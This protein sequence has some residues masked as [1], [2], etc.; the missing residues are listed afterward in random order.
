M[1]MNPTSIMSELRMKSDKELQD[2]AAMHKNDPFIFPL[3]FQESQTRQRMRTAEQAKAA[4]QNQPKVVDQDLAQMS[5]MPVMSGYGIPVT[6]GDGSPVMSGMPEDSGIAQLSAKNL[7]GMAGGGIVAFEE[8]GEVPRFQNTG[9][10]QLP[11][12]V[13]GPKGTVYVRQPNHTDEYWAN[14]LEK[15]APD[16]L[17]S[18]ATG[19]V[20]QALPGGLGIYSQG[21]FGPQAGDAALQKRI[22]DIEANP[23]MQRADKDMLIAKARQ[24]FGLPKVTTIPPTTPVQFGDKPATTTPTTT[25]GTSPLINKEQSVVDKA[26][27]RKRL[28]DEA[29]AQGRKLPPEPGM[30]SI[31]SYMKQFE[32]AL[33][34]KEEAQSEE[35][36]MNKRSEPMKEY[37]EKAN[38]TI[39]KE[40]S[41][42]NTDKEQDF[43]MALIQGGLAAAGESGPNALQNIAKGFA[44]GTSSYA[45]AL[46]DFRK[47]AQENRKMEMDLMKAKAADKKGDMDA[48]QKH[49]ESVAERNA[50]IDQ[51]KTSGVAQLLGH[52]MSASA[53]LGAAKY[54]REAMGDYRNSSQVETIRKNIDAK[55]GDDPKYKFDAAKRAAEVERRLQIELQ[56]YPNLVG[57]AGSPTGGGATPTLKYNEK[58]GQLD[59]VG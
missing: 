20:P 58:T 18:N 29:A 5:P 43:Y 4:G 53:T 33:P 23:R 12:R 7:E 3:A 24:E 45:G 2:F 54:N 31:D 13:P 25:Q 48:Y 39:Q 49:T 59:K 32:A 46:K 42:L 38:A 41:R 8:G 26:V 17:P 9:L 6:A 44:V 57:Y 28:E 22:A 47:A 55:L 36:F 19:S 11:S 16:S 14:F 34:E 30:P 40:A 27:E 35:T 15:Y 51:Y 1:A 50:K 56:R 52:Q 37:F 10:V 21:A